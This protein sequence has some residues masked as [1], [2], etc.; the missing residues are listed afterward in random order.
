M[1][2]LE[3]LR[4]EEACLEK[5]I[6][7]NKTLMRADLPCCDIAALAERLSDCKKTIGALTVGKLFTA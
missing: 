5:E 7:H 3:T 6:E 1:S 4:R 2:E